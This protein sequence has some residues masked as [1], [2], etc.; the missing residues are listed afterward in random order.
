MEWFTGDVGSAITL[1]KSKNAIFC[2]YITGL[3]HF[4]TFITTSGFTQSGG[5]DGSK[6]SGMHTQCISI[7][8]NKMFSVGAK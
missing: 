2:V 5:L 1:A 4:I 8:L 7:M 6:P 3:N